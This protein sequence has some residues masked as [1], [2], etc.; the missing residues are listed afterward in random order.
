MN[1]GGTLDLHVLGIQPTGNGSSSSAG[2]GD[3]VGAPSAPRGAGNDEQPTGSGF[4]TPAEDD[5][6]TGGFSA[7]SGE[8]GGLKFTVHS[9]LQSEH[10]ILYPDDSSV[11]LS[12]DLVS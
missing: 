12:K 10:V 7:D 4:K 11:A 1:G 3:V 8:I 9:A 5:D 2:V 6:A